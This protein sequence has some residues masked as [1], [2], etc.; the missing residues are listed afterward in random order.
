MELSDD[1]IILRVQKGHIQDYEILVIRYQNSLIRFLNRFIG[2][3]DEAEGIA[4][5]TFVRVYA[6]LPRYR[7]QERFKAL[8]F[9]SARNLAINFIKKQQRNLP[10]SGFLTPGKEH[11]H[12]SNQET[13]E[14][15]YDHEDQNARIDAALRDLSHNQRLALVLKVYLQ[16][17]YKQIREVTGWSVAKIETLVSR[18]RA[19]LQRRIEMQDPLRRTVV[20]LEEKHDMQA[21]S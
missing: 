12:F 13:P 14:T 15:A 19:S 9:T 4:Q 21:H 5:E 11:A 16:Y 1:D 18:A 17:S 10:L 3:P 7:P 20:H 6:A 8:L 2:D